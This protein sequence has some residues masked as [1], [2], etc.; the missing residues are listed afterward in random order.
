M[1]AETRILT[2]RAAMT[3]IVSRDGT[4]IAYRTSGDGAPLLLVHGTSGSH[5]RFAPLL[6][7]LEPYAT[8][9]A[10]DRR[11]RGGSGDAPE[12]ELAR[13]FE[14]VAATVDAI[15]AASGA[16]VDV[17]GHSYGGEC[18]FGAALLTSN[19]RSLVLYEGWPPVL[20][21]KLKFPSGVEKRLDDLVAS[22]D[23]EEALELFWRE[24]VKVSDE[25]IRTIRAQPTWPARVATVHTIT[26]EFRGFFGDTF[27]PQRAARITVPVLLLA[28]TDT[29]DELRDDP[30]TVAAALPDARIVYLD[31]Q[32]HIADVLAPEQFAE[33]VLEFLHERP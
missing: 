31:G 26:R 3:R 18:A 6:P 8:V 1:S 19:I 7:Y 2:S 14:D 10:M 12:Y 28:G 15:A 20:P 17:Y 33:H 27:D 24:V 29:P 32:Q 11:G 13:E 23:R 25:D 22:G 30:E 4:K 5:E 16:K 21:E 9:H